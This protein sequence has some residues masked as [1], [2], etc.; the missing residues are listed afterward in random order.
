[1]RLAQS[2]WLI[3]G[4]T[5]GIGLAL[6][7]ALSRR[8]A[9]FI[10]WGRDQAALARLRGDNAC[11]DARR[12]DL[13]NAIALREAAAA[14]REVAPNLNGVLHGAAIQHARAFDDDAMGESAIDEEVATN[15]R[16]PIA[17]TRLLLP[18]LRLQ[19]EAAVVF[20]TSALAWAPKRDAAV[21]AAT[22]AGL[23]Q[24]A[25]ALRLQTRGGPVRVIEAV[26]PLVDT[27][28]TTGRRSRKISAEA[29]AE[30]IARG[31]SAG[32]ERIWVG[33]VWVLAGLMRVVP[34]VGRWVMGRG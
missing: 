6:T 31:L 30:A 22:K 18:R 7:H 23:R 28:M 13:R 19:S 15:L 33:K 2:T 16:A 3:T 5:S 8:G 10:A 26:P 25:E 9:R 34:E 32:Q 21:Y 4:A 14:I 11:V 1:M 24:F 29:C 20:I 27:P 17:L 12:V